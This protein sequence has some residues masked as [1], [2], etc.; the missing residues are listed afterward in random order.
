MPSRFKTP[1][2]IPARNALWFMLVALLTVTSASAQIDKKDA[3]RRGRES[4]Y[5]LKK[6]G[7]VGFRAS[8][9]PEWELMFKDNAPDPEGLRLLHGLHFSV[10]FGREGNVVINHSSDS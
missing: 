9:R 6:L 8:I 4:Y 7:L 3:V 5:N 1:L 2:R 10:L